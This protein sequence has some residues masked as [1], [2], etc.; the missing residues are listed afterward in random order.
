[1]LP[2]IMLPK[3]AMRI[4]RRQTGTMSAA[5]DAPFI[6]DAARDR[7]TVRGADALDYLQSQLAQEVRDLDVGSTRWTLVLE[8]TGKITTLARVTRT[9]EDTFV[10]DTDSGYGEQLAARINRFKIRVDADVELTP[11]ERDAPSAEHEDARIAAAWPRMGAEI[12]PGETIPAVTGIVEHSVDFTKGCYPGQE[13]VERMD[14][15]GATAPKQ[16][17][18]VDAG[19][20][21]RPGDPITDADGNDVGVIT[22]VGSSAALG[23]VKR[24]ADVGRRPD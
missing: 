14:S 16:L 24:G 9:A 15:R 2:S 18:I 23:Y 19:P 13:L 5:A 12:E 20:A 11:A 3:C 17:R 1:M 10:L 22:S 21:T 7:V 6:D 4:A 8:P